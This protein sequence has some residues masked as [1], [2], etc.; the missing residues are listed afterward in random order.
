MTE[1]GRKALLE[2]REVATGDSDPLQLS[3]PWGGRSPRSLTKAYAMFSLTP[4]ASRP[5]EFFDDRVL[6]DQYR[7]FLDSSEEGK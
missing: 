1:A 4:E 3:L 7:R 6:E 2:L 5:D